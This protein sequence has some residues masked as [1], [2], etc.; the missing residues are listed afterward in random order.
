MSI[1]HRI[2]SELKRLRTERKFSLQDL[3]ATTQVSRASISRIENSEVSPTTQVLVKLCKALGVSVSQLILRCE[4]HQPVLVKF[5]QQQQWYDS[6][7]GFSRRCVSPPDNDYKAEVLYCELQ[8]GSVINYD[9]SPD[10][11][12]EHHLYLQQG[13]LNLII[14][15]SAYLLSQGD[16]LRYKLSQGNTFEVIGDKKASYLLV[17]VKQ[18]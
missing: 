9:C 11:D 6:E 15:D 4:T 17:L 1:D 16:C 5:D 7:N 2:A 18:S 3:A 14:N 8:P 12:L 10:D 13:Q